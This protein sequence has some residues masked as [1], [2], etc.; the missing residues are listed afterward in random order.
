MRVAG[1]DH[2][3]LSSHAQNVPQ[4]IEFTESLIDHG[5]NEDDVGKILGGNVVRVLQET[6]G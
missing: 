1:I 2:V 4:W 5:Y 3:G 6:I